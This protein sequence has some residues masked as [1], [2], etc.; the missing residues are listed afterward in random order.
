M[1]AKPIVLIDDDE[2]VRESTRL[3]L[4]S[5]GFDVLDFASAESFL[6]AKRDGLG[7]LLVDQHMPG[8][9]GID[10][11]ET[12]RAQGDFTPALMITGRGDAALEDRTGAI[13]IRLLPKP[14]DETEL[15]GILQQLTPDGLADGAMPS[16][17]LSLST[18]PDES[19]S[20]HIG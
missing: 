6:A 15:V 9:S 4:E 18:D 5:Y 11:L 16:G 12:L 17:V 7:C 3:L 10:L 1:G 20:G 2:A 14:V 13:G 19:G 8:M